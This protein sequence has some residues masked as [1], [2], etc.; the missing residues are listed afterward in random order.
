ME[1]NKPIISLFLQGLD[2]VTIIFY[3]ITN[4]NK[5]TLTIYKGGAMHMNTMR[6]EPFM[7][8]L[9]LQEKMNK[10]FEETVSPH[11]GKEA[12][13]P[14]GI[15]YP[16]VDILENDKEIIIKAELPG[17]DLSDVNLEVTDNLLTLKG[18]RQFE[19]DRKKENYH[20]VER[21]YGSFHRSFT[22]PGTVDQ[23]KINARLKDGILLVTLPK[24]E[25][26]KPKQIPVE[27]M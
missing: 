13:I 8:L 23:S 6:W 5:S 19:G 10:L 3:N 7:D 15:W 1:E 27:S 26:L 20:R 25:N 12:E 14:T 22:L 17:I 11:A 16:V 9:S 4:I 24:V 21:S 2:N 18:E